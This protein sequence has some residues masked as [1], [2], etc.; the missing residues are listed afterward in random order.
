MKSVSMNG[1][2]TTSPMG[3]EKMPT[4]TGS[5][6]QSGV[7]AREQRHTGQRERQGQHE[8]VL[9]V[10]QVQRHD[11]REAPG[12]PHVVDLPHVAHVEVEATPGSVPAARMT[13]SAPETYCASQ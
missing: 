4:A 13:M 7:P 1:T 9:A 5:A 12:R 2:T 6:A 8:G 11:E 3:L 10:R